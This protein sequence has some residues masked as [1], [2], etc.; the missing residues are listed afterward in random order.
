[1]AQP[2]KE[3]ETGRAART[4]HIGNENFTPGWGSVFETYWGLVLRRGLGSDCKKY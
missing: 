4:M 1:M 3:V 2:E